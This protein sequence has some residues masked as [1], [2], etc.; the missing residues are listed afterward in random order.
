MS[1]RFSNQCGFDSGLRAPSRREF[2]SAVGRSALVLP[3]SSL[4]PGLS[5]LQKPTAASKARSANSSSVS[6]FSFT[7]IT[8]QA[9]LACAL[10]VFGGVAKKQYILEETGCGV[11]LFDYDNDGWLD[12]FL[13]NGTR[14][15][16]ISPSNA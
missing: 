15:E 9:G 1:R 5:A 16:G 10:N 13:V 2:L 14:L 4:V 12:I 3:F 7:D 11:A 8:K 6:G